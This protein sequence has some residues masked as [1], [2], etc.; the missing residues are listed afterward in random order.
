MFSN[1]IT[2]SSFAYKVQTYTPESA[3]NTVWIKTTNAGLL[4][5][6]ADPSKRFE[7]PDG[8]ED[9]IRI[10]GK[11]G[12]DFSEYTEEHTRFNTG[13]RAYTKHEQVPKAFLYVDRAPFHV[14]DFLRN[15]VL[16][17]NTIA[18][19]DYNS[20]NANCHVGTMWERSGD[21]SPDYISQVSKASVKLEFRS[22]FQNSFKARCR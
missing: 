15:E 12:D 14:R 4:G 5:N 16:M 19:F 11:F 1:I 7:F 22:S 8:W 20:N 17:A 21:F 9:G 13:F 3:D 2:D 18:M 6:I 10:K